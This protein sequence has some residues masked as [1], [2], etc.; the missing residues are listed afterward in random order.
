MHD[1]HARQVG[2]DRLAAGLGA[3]AWFILALRGGFE[4]DFGAEDLVELGDRFR[5]VK[6]LALAGGDAELLAARPVAIGLQDPKRLFQE[7]DAPLASCQLGSA[8]GIAAP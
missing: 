7:P 4:V 8:L 3:G 5:F 2:G 6:E 1:R